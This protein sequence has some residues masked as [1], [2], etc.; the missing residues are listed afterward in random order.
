MQACFVKGILLK[1]ITLRF[2]F[3]KP[4]VLLRSFFA[5]HRRLHWNFQLSP[6]VFDGFFVFTIF[7]IDEIKA[8]QSLSSLLAL[9]SFGFS[10]THSCF[11]FFCMA[12]PIPDQISCARR[13]SVLRVKIVVGHARPLSEEALVYRGYPCRDPPVCHRICHPKKCGVR[14]TNSEVHWKS[15]APG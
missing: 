1:F 9:S 11:S 3:L 7:R 12:F 5:K 2:S 14:A 10:F 6:C 4:G 8:S 13:C 15:R